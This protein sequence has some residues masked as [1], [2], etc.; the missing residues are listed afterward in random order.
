MEEVKIKRKLLAHYLNT[1][2][3]SKPEWS[4][5]GKGISEMEMS[6]NPEEESVKYIH[7]DSSTNELTGYNVTSDVTQTC[8]AGEPIFEYV[9]EKRKIRAIENDAE[10]QILD[11]NM[12]DKLA[13]NVYSAELSGAIIIIQTFSGNSISY[14]V[15]RNGDPKIG[16]VTVSNSTITFTEGKYSE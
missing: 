13:E 15:K 11:V 9:D 5:M 8:Y 14:N 12:Y 2:S 1:G 4:R 7:E 16:Y 6:Y 10:T 3:M